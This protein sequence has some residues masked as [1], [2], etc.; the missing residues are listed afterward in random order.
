ME[1]SFASLPVALGAEILPFFGN[2]PETFKNC[3][4]SGQLR[5]KLGEHLVLVVNSRHISFSARD[6]VSLTAN[7]RSAHRAFSGIYCAREELRLDGIRH[8]W[9]LHLLLEEGTADCP[10][11]TCCLR[12]CGARGTFG[13]GLA[14]TVSSPVGDKRETS[15]P[16]ALPY[17]T[18]QPHWWACPSHAVSLWD[19][20]HTPVAVTASERGPI[21]LCAPS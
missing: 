13:R 9:G 16:S 21:R 17:T 11:S 15:R 14:R 3:W 18:P 10:G 6:C 8:G 7:D 2:T 4:S 20:R 1:L 5:K 19:P 12:P